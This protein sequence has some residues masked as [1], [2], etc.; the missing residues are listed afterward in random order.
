MIQP[1]IELIER[2]DDI[3][4]E[5]MYLVNTTELYIKIR[6]TIIKDRKCTFAEVGAKSPNIAIER[7]EIYANSKSLPPTQTN[8][9]GFRGGISAYPTNRLK[10]KALSAQEFTCDIIIIK[11]GQ[12]RKSPYGGFVP[13]CIGLYSVRFDGQITEIYN[14]QDT[15]GML[16]IKTVHNIGQFMV[17]CNIRFLMDLITKQHLTYQGWSYFQGDSFINKEI[18]NDTFITKLHFSI[19]F[20]RQCAHVEIEENIWQKTHIIRSHASDDEEETEYEDRHIYASFVFTETSLIKFISNV[21]T[22]ASW[23]A[24]DIV[25]F[26]KTLKSEFE[27]VTGIHLIETIKCYSNRVLYL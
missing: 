15:E 8:L 3:L 2:C 20:P 4:Q 6:S 26:K 13:F 5:N 7:N 12:L 10:V 14:F 11:G 22:I 25:F 18:T 16:D 1:I 24:T 23:Q 9:S 27:K 17:P 19:N 21:N